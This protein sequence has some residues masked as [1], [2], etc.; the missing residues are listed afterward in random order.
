MTERKKRSSIN[1]VIVED[2]KIINDSLSS[3]INRAD[4]FA[5]VGSFLDCESMLKIIASLNADILLMDIKLPGMNGIEGVKAVKELLPELNI[6]MLTVHEE[7]ELIFDAL[8]AGACGY[9]V[10]K[11]HPERLLEAIQEAHEGGAPMSSHIARKVTQFF[12]NKKRLAEDATLLTERELEILKELIK[13]KTYYSIAMTLNIS[14]DTVRFH[15]KRIYKK[16]HVHSQA[17]AVAKAI[18]KGYV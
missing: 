18:T 12:Q 14:K 15:I 17:E 7:N 8:C 10:K 6:L 3:L 9:L 4:G 1:V 2:T 5:C 13:G 16:L 11:T